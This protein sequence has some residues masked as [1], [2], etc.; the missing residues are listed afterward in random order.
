MST[1]IK[2]FVR[3]LLWILNGGTRRR[4]TPQRFLAEYLQTFNA[5]KIYLDNET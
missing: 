4:Y 1:V 5:K 3:A 2:D